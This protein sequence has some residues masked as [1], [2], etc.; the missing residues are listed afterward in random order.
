MLQRLV[1]V[2]YWTAS[3]LALLVVF[4]GVL[5][6]VTQQHQSSSDW[7]V[8]IVF[9]SVVAGLIWLGRPI[10]A[11]RI[12]EVTNLGTYEPCYVEERS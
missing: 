10:R 8:L 11:R 1:N 7:I 4:F 6:A 9:C 12:G 2:I 3:G 5:I